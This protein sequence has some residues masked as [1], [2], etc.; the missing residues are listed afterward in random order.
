MTTSKN[1]ELLYLFS[2]ANLDQCLCSSEALQESQLN[3]RLSMFVCVMTSI[4]ISSGTVRISNSPK[5]RLEVDDCNC[6]I[7]CEP[8]AIPKDFEGDFVDE[9]LFY[10][11]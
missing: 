7:N 9:L 8:K 1:Q 6:S 4:C 5:I 10:F 11:L 2:I 3:S